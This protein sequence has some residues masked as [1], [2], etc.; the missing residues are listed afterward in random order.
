MYTTKKKKATPIS[1]SATKKAAKKKAS[2]S[3]NKKP[4]TKSSSVLVTAA[5]EL[6]GKSKKGKLISEFLCR[7]W[8]AMTWPDPAS[9]PDETPP[10]CDVLDGFPGVFVTTSGED[11]GKILD[12][13][14]ESACPNFINMAK[15]SS[16]ELKELL[17]TAIE[18]QRR[19]LIENEGIGTQTEKD[20]NTLE[21]WVS[22]VNA[23]TADK[24]AEKVLKA[25]KT[26]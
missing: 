15:K 3:K 14:D 11:T 10:N 13:R 2:P 4:D 9:I 1:T 25:A 19:V 7:W 17:L 24:E 5:S 23:K 18:E 21:K 12:M 20:L 6:Y 26:D 8:Y 16:E 22:K